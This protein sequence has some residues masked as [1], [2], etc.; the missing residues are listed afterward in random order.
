M[1]SALGLFFLAPLLGEY[2]LG[3]ISIRHIAGLIVLAPMYGGGALLIREAA[4]QTG[5]GWPTMALLALAYGIAEPALF[6]RSLFN[7]SFD[8]RDFQ[9]ATY[10]PLFGISVS[11][12]IAFCVGHAVWSISVPIAI[13]ESLAPNRR[14]M[15]WVGPFGLFVTC[16]LFMAGVYMIFQDHVK[17]EHFLPSTMQL[18]VSAIVVLGFIVAAF[19]VRRKQLIRTNLQAPNKW[20]VGATSF[21]ISSLFFVLGESWW[22][23]VVKILLL[24]LMIGLVIN[25]S[26][27]SGWRLRHQVALT[28][29]LLLT[30][31]WGGFLCS[32][33]VGNTAAIDRVGNSVFAIS[34]VILLLLAVRQSHRIAE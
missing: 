5:R 21:A 22:S 15:P 13:I 26:K 20:L 28:G 31:V 27:R 1:L 9:D 6:D 33:L 11:N 19:A 34:G 30:Y 4:R 18:V 10:I 16:A 8:G 32:T 2:L 7:M 17:T 3:N 23:V 24:G 25:W 29:G 14:M 12:T